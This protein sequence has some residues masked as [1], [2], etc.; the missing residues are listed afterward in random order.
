MAGPAPKSAPKSGI[1]QRTDLQALSFL[2][3]GARET[4]RDRHIDS[5]IALWRE[6]AADAGGVPDKADFSIRKLKPYLTSYFLAEW[7]DDD[8]VNRLIGS[9]YD[10]KFAKG[11]TGTSFFAKFSGFQR[12]FFHTFWRQ[13]VDHPCGVLMARTVV[14]PTGRA[15]RLEGVDLPLADRHGDVRFICGVGDV[16]TLH[17][18][19]VDPSEERQVF[20]DHIEYLDLGFGVPT[21]RPDPE[22]FNAANSAAPPI[23]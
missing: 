9:Q 5:F 23:C 16:R 7:V 13:L 3:G 2:R 4:T 14:E 20:I 1:T 22:A 10:D 21:S 17:G 11:L 15:I 19:L 12:D 6:L 8:L 18:A